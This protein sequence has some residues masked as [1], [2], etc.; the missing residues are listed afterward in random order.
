MVF[1]LS[2]WAINIH[3]LTTGLY[4]GRICGLACLALNAF[5][6]LGMCGRL[7]YV[8]NN[9]MSFLFVYIL[10]NSVMAR[11][12]VLFFSQFVI[13]VTGGNFYI[14]VLLQNHF[15]YFRNVSQV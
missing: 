4:T 12:E 5:S 1:L 9:F 3:I 10:T 8:F 2:L 11:V 13:H 15:C 14:G 6:I 7:G